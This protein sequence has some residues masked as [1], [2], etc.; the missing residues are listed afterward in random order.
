MCPT[1][2]SSRSP[3][4]GGRRVRVI[5]VTA[6]RLAPR[7]DDFIFARRDFRHDLR[8]SARGA[9]V[10]SP[11]SIAGANPVAA[12]QSDRR[13]VSGNLAG[14]R[15]GTQPVGDPSGPLR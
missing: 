9:A 5:R 2:G 3:D 11:D 1:P 10:A 12:N 13:L 6:L 8:T 4:A 7:Q 14:R 15:S